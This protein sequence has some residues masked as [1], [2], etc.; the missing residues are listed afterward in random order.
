MN[1]GGGVVEDAFLLDFVDGH[2]HGDAQFAGECLHEAD[3]GAVGDGL[4]DVVPSDGLFGAEVGAVENLLEADDLGAGG[5]GLADAGRRVCRSWPASES[6][7][8][9]WPGTALDAWMM[10]QRTMRGMVS[11]LQS[12]GGVRL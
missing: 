9:R 11:R 4:S 8:V 2:D 6:Q 5:G 7:A 1:D 10:E 12:N 3:G